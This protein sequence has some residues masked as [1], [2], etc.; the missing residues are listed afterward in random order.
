M[1]RSRE[2]IFTI[3]K[4]SPGVAVL[5][6]N[7]A[8]MKNVLNQLVYQKGGWTLHMF[9]ASMGTEKFWTGIRD[10]YHRYRDGSASTE[11][12]RRVTEENSG[13]SCHGS[14][15]SGSRARDL[16][17]SRATGDMMRRRNE[18]RSN[19]RKLQTGEPYRLPFRSA[20]TIEGA[21][22]IEKIEMSQ[23][24][25]RF[26]IAADKEPSAVVLDP[27]TWVLMEARFAKRD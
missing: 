16:R 19:W 26:E 1:Q 9:G 25:Q 14:F 17:R 15:G 6:N 8:D 20:L 10:Y 24:Q 3:E 23:K 22:K 27:N 2:K 21:P 18:S 7:L 5:H 4:R 13:R 11:D 12:F